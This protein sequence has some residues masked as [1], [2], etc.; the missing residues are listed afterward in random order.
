MKKVIALIL[1][2]LTAFS[3]CVFAFAEGEDD[4][5]VNVE[6]TVN[7][8]DHDL[9]YC[10]FCH[11]AFGSK[12]AMA[13][14][15]ASCEAYQEASHVSNYHNNCEYCGEAFVNEIA[16]NTHMEIYNHAA[17]HVATCK[18]TD[19][20]WAKQHG[21]PETFWDYKNGGCGMKFT[22]QSELKRH[23]EQCSHKDDYTTWKNI[24]IKAAD[25]LKKGFEL[26]KKV[27]WGSVLS[28]I[29]E[30]VKKIPWK[31]IASKI[32]DLVGGISL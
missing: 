27:D 10:E 20:S 12:E 21:L 4:G 18:Y 22:R 28:K 19:N 30:V 32:G 26:L 2:L 3:C 11:T 16:F 25:L 6:V 8:Y 7:N 5:K 31:D 1:A 24:K 14:H 9:W 15:Y 23:E 29:V 13:S 17:N